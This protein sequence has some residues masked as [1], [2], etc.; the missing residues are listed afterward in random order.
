MAD[1]AEFFSSPKIPLFRLTLYFRFF[2]PQTHISNDDKRR[3][4]F[5][6]VVLEPNKPSGDTS[7]IQNIL[8]N[9]YKN[10]ENDIMAFQSMRLIRRL[11]ITTEARLF[12]LSRAGSGTPSCSPRGRCWTRTWPC[13]AA[14]TCRTGRSASSPSAHRSTSANSNHTL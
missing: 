2:K 10:K 1:S 13:P 6:T 14:R 4:R 9:K 8:M 7:T 12:F 11:N 5:E 3:K